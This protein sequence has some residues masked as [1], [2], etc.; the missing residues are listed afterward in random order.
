MTA[1][2][3]S[4][5]PSDPNTLIPCFDSLVDDRRLGQFLRELQSTAGEH[6]L[7]GGAVRDLLIGIGRPRDIDL[8]VPNGDRVAHRLL[9]KYDSGSR[10][11]HGKASAET[12]GNSRSKYNHCH[13][14]I[15]GFRR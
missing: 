3:L 1:P 11:R 4:N 7:V 14:P 13:F 6:Y 10:N 9:R 2:H 8:I 12:R 15:R 5:T